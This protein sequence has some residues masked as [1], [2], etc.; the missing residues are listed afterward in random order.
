MVQVCPFLLCSLLPSFINWSVE[1]VSAEHIWTCSKVGSNNPNVSRKKAK[2]EEKNSKRLLEWTKWRGK[3]NKKLR[4][5]DGKQLLK[6]TKEHEREKEGSSRNIHHANHIEI[7]CVLLPSLRDGTNCAEHPTEACLKNTLKP[8][9][10]HFTQNL[11]ILSYTSLWSSFSAMTEVFWRSV[12]LDFCS[13]WWGWTKY[14]CSL[15]SGERGNCY[16]RATVRIC[17]N[18]PPC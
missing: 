8:W 4:E 15:Q 17:S 13:S 11:W 12:A 18:F 3:K 1:R 9:L 7:A 14:R 5:S 2:N 16:Q 10:M 6:T